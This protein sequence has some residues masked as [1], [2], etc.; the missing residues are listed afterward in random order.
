MISG[1]YRVPFKPI[2]RRFPAK[3]SR[4]NPHNWFPGLPNEWSEKRL[5][6]RSLTP[7]FCR[8]VILWSQVPG[9]S[10][11]T[12]IFIRI[13]DE[14]VDK[15]ASGPALRSVRRRQISTVINRCSVCDVSKQVGPPETTA[16][17]FN[18][19]QTS[20]QL[21]NSPLRVMR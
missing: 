16:G 21:K 11:A 6:L 8:I 12:W 15:M 9:L 18:E 7:D 10:L 13:A 2:R 1:E 19:K 4:R 14:S 3:H 17:D 20:P 5:R